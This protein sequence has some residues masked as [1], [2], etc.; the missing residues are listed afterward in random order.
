MVEYGD[1]ERN[2]MMERGVTASE[3]TTGGVERGSTEL[4]IMTAVLQ[5][6]VWRLNLF[7]KSG[8]HGS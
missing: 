3:I 6:S 7:L 1:Q 2:F 8:T 4:E 5:K